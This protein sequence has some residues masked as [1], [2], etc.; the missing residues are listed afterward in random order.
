MTGLF[1]ST[2]NAS[3]VP[4]RRLGEQH[5]PEIESHLLTLS[6]A[7]RYLRFGYAAKDEH[8]ARYVSRLDFE[9]DEVFGIFNRN[10]ALLAMAHMAYVIEPGQPQRVEFGVSVVPDA[11]GRGYGKLLFDR[12]VTHARNQGVST[13]FIHALT[14]NKVMLGI[15]TQAGATVVHEG[16]ESQAHLLLPSASFESQ[17]QEL[18][19][20]QVA[21]T[22][23]HLKAQAKQIRGLLDVV[24]EIRDGVRDARGK[25]GP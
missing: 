16:A 5:R 18:L 23:Y 14:E 12:A 1:G 2:L 8:V 25:A 9:R 24:H 10:L 13:L 20:E 15:A 21:R 19:E 17:V 4:I 3:R 6:S 7:D 11:R 22:D